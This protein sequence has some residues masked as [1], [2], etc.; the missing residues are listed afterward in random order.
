MLYPVISAVEG[1]RLGLS[2]DMYPKQFVD[3]ATAAPVRGYNWPSVNVSS[4]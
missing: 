1:T 3:S 4:N 2:R